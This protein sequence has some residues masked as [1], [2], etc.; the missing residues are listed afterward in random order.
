MLQGWKVT[1]TSVSAVHFPELLAVSLPPPPTFF[2]LLTK[3]VYWESTKN[4]NLGPIPIV[5]HKKILRQSV[6]QTVFIE[7]K[8][9]F[10]GYGPNP[11]SIAFH[12]LDQEEPFTG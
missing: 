3:R 5:S 4:C 10:E 1:T 8:G 11:V 2:L 12:W 7:G 9:S 6:E